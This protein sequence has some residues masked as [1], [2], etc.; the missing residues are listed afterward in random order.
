MIKFHRNQKLGYGAL[1]SADSFPLKSFP[2]AS[3]PNDGI[4]LKSAENFMQEA[5]PSFQPFQLR[6]PH[7]SRFS[8][9]GCHQYLGDHDETSSR[10]A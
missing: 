3:G 10:P 7:P 6:L 8:K 4:Q 9:G 2:F 5:G 1:V